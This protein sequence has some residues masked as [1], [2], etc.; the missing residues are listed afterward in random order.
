ML[1]AITPNKAR[2]WSSLIDEKARM[3]RF[4]RTDDLDTPDA[5]K[6]SNHITAMVTRARCKSPHH[7]LPF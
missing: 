1:T 4:H 6:Y 5:F 7:S 2:T 3:I